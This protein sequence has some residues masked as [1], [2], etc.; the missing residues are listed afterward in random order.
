MAVWLSEEQVLISSEVI[1]SSGVQFGT[2][3]AR[4]LVE[5]FTTDTC[6]AFTHAFLS[7][8]QDR[9]SFRQVAVAIDNRPSSP[10]MAKSVVGAIKQ[11][12]MEVLYYGVIPTPA[13]A[14]SAMQDGI[15]CIMVTGSHIPFD[16]NGLKF[17]RPDGEISKAD[18][19]AILTA[20]VQFAS[21]LEL[22]ELNMCSSAAEKY[23]N[24]YTSL[25]NDD[26]LSDKRIGIYEH[27]SAGRD[28]YSTL[29]ESLGA[30]VISLERSDEFVPIDTEAV[31]DAD[32][33][34]AKIWSVEHKLDFIF[35]TDGD[36]D[37]PLVAD[38]NG[39]WLRGDILGLLCAQEMRIEALA[40]PV[41]C[42]TIIEKSKTFK[43]VS[44]TKIGSPYVIA[45]FD[46]LSEKYTRIAGFEANGGFLLG[47]DIEVNG[48]ALK[49]LPTRDAVLPA[50]MLLSAAKNI[51][52]ANLVSD[53]PQRF[54]HSDRIQNFA[55]EKS[56]AILAHGIDAPETLIKSL[57]F[58]ESV[59]DV[60]ITDGLRMTL[61]S[62][63]IVHLRPSGNAPELRCYAEA[64]TMQQA[65]DIVL[66]VLDKVKNLDIVLW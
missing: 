29:F 10:M 66:S 42:N 58:D 62:G 2:S 46:I 48:K 3:G 37:R 5:Q 43:A 65:S 61:T 6:A 20:N 39:D 28:I 9:F 7:G 63:V 40:I 56:L 57:G 49:G 50:L 47:A 51:T 36:G 38:E 44:K 64:D 54:S 26:M 17:Y 14:Y 12:G 15:P 19:Q 22:P 24:R 35:S 41:S 4:G 34:K 18:E 1:K 25:F 23:A 16:R 53:L 52:I 45:E 27:S 32:K 11:L 59:V 33:A 8:L 21:I 60:D 55:T 31:S 13:L 30:E